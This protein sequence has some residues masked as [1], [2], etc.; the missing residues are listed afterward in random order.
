MK[1]ASPGLPR[2]T[3]ARPDGTRVPLMSFTI[4]ISL[5][6]WTPPKIRIREMLLRMNWLAAG[7]RVDTVSLTIGMK[8][9]HALPA[10]Q[11]PQNV[12]AWLPGGSPPA[13][14]AAAAWSGATATAQTG[15]PSRPAMVG[16]VVVKS[17]LEPLA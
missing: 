10:G 5:V 12:R 9:H 8:L 14:F 11:P 7:E 17:S 15:R 2:W 4:L 3:I 1:N 13:I 6:A 16:G